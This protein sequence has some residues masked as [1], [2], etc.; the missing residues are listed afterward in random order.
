MDD[1]TIEVLMQ[2][3]GGWCAIIGAALLAVASIGFG[4]LTFGR[5][6]EAVLQYLAAQPAWYWPAVHLAFAAGAVFWIGAFI[7]LNSSF[8]DIMP[9]LLGSLGVVA[10]VLGAALHVIDSF[11]SGSALTALAQQWAAAPVAQRGDIVRSTDTLLMVLGGTWTGVVVLFHGVPFVLDGTA[12]ARSERYP[13]PLKWIGALAGFGS[14]VTG[15]LMLM[16]PGT[17]PPALYFVFAGVGMVWMVGVGIVLK[18]A[19][20]P[21]RRTREALQVA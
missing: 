2:R 14:V 20:V 9:R 16:T 17:V 12:V 7:A 15:A 1:E 8:R 3:L 4:G 10:M 11:I 6:P 13:R 21:A 18:R 5:E 19:P